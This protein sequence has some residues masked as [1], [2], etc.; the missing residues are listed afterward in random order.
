M[1]RNISDC[2]N[3]ARAKAG[4]FCQNGVCLKISERNWLGSA[5][6]IPPTPPSR[7]PRFACPTETLEWR[8]EPE[9][10]GQFQVFLWRQILF[11]IAI[12]RSF[13]AKQ[14]F[15]Q[16]PARIFLLIAVRRP[17]R[18]ESLQGVAKSERFWVV[19][20]FG[21]GNAERS[22]IIFERLPARFFASFFL[23]EKIWEFRCF[24]FFF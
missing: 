21:G 13:W 1:S 23:K 24:W 11:N 14:K 22:L 2:Q 12:K 5:G 10:K 15:G 20:A 7:P 9:R 17:E 16:N 3:L 8:R 19:S 18:S 4:Q 6:G